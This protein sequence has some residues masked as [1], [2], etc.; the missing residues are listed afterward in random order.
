METVGTV[1]LT[2]EDAI[3]R[4]IIEERKIQ[5]WSTISKILKDEFG[6]LN[7]EDKDC[8]DR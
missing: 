2:Q 5:K 7:R 1:V 6:I 4:E 3:L 8:K